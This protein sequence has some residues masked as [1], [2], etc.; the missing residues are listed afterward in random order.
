MKF[1]NMIYGFGK[2]GL[3]KVCVFTQ[4][5]QVEFIFMILSRGSGLQNLLQL[6]LLGFYTNSAHLYI[7]INEKLLCI[8]YLL[9]VLLLYS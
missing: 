3:K 2:K 8:V 9:F 4:N 7:T 5:Y 1:V 6:Q